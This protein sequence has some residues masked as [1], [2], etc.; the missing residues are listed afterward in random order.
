MDATSLRWVLAIIGIIILVGVYLY[1]IYQNKLRRSAAIK[2]LTHE[3]LES[4]VIEDETLRNELS[5]INTMLDQEDLDDE[6]QGIKINPA[7][8]HAVKPKNEKKPEIHLPQSLHDILTENLVAHVLKHA[9]DRVLTGIEV[10][11]AFIHAN[12]EMNEDGFVEFKESPAAR[13]RFL[14]MTLSGSFLEIDDPQFYSYGLVCFFD[15][16]LCD[17][18]VSCYE[19]MLKKIDELVRILD[20]KVYNEDLQLLTLQHVTETRNRLMSGTETQ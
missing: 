3:E 12:L 20:L 14:N 10:K 19:L 16:A 4:G 8:D 5:S 9:D 2:T 17:K 13:F 1:T 11:N 7:V 6:I 15:G 18:P